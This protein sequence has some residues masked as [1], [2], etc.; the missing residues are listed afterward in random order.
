MKKS[1]LIL[2]ASG[3]FGRHA[4]SSFS[5][6]GWE[7]TKFNRSIDKL[8]DAAWGADVIL[9]A[10]NPE[11][12]DWEQQLPELTRTIIATAKETGATVLI[13][14]NVYSYGPEMPSV[15]KDTT[16]HQATKGLGKLRLD[17]EAAYKQS[18]VRTIVLRAGDF[19]DTSP[20][21]NWFD[22]VITKNLAKGRLV[23]PG[24]LNID[25]AWAY[26]PDLA[27]AAVQLAELRDELGRFEEVLFPGFNLS[28]QQLQMQLSRILRRDLKL[29]E[30]SWWPVIM[31]QPVWKMARYL[32]E[33]R[34]LWN[35]PHRIESEKFARL[36]PDFRPTDLTEALT[37]SLPQDVHPNEK[38]P[39]QI[40]LTPGSRAHD[41]RV[42]N[43]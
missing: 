13:P 34:Y 11:Y 36:L 27:D 41:T 17:M 1:V 4:A 29:S 43:N 28:A 26:L 10:W 38:M 30:M 12:P 18:D 5:W 14:G 24:H 39:R 23:Y 20:S 9:N 22:K 37:N 31:A 7:V 35:T 6:A 2:G 15:L 40:V 8:P 3:R 19:I 21:G 16:P 32:G 42:F 25:H 33:M